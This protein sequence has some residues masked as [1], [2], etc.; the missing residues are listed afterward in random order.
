MPLPG[1]DSAV[2][3]GVTL[4]LEPI[5]PYALAPQRVGSVD[6]M[7]DGSY[8]VQVMGSDKNWNCT[9]TYVTDATLASL[10]TAC[11]TGS[12]VEYVGPG[13]TGAWFVVKSFGDPVKVGLHWTLSLGLLKVS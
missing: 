2:L 8:E 6:R 11:A 10:T 13:C 9:L 5:P 12:V 3:G 1:A 7:L 4:D